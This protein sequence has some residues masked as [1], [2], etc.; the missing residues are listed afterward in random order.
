MYICH[1]T[2]DDLIVGFLGEYQRR[3]DKAEHPFEAA[4]VVCGRKGKYQLSPEV[5]DMLNGPAVGAPVMIVGYSTHDAM[6]MI[7]RFTPK[8]NID[9]T[10]RV[11]V[12]T[13]VR[14]HS[15]KPELC[16]LL[17]YVVLLLSFVGASPPPSSH[18]RAARSSL[19]QRLLLQHY[20]PYID[21]SELLRR[22]QSSNSSFNEPGALPFEELRRL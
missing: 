15:G 14:E 6:S 22:T 4:L 21:F 10:N 5:E 2:R 8:L 9:D 11:M 1:V 16:R 17:L 12:A 20:E 18:P 7:H 19:A 13:E 3:R